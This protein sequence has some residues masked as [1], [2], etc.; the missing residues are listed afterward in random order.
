MRTLYILLLITVVCWATMLILEVRREVP[1][2]PET[3]LAP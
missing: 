1:I 3:H 2:L